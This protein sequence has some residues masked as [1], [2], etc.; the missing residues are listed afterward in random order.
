MENMRIENLSDVKSYIED[1]LLRL[2]ALEKELAALKAEAHP[3][4]DF[5]SNTEAID[6]SFDVIDNLV[7]DNIKEEDSISPIEVAEENIVN[8]EIAIEKEV[9]IEESPAVVEIADKEAESETEETTADVA[10]VT[11]ETEEAAIEEEEEEDYSESLFGSDFAPSA[12]PKGRKSKK[13][14]ILNDV[15][16]ESSDSVIDRLSDKKTWMRDIPGSEVKS[17][18]S[19]IALGDQVVYIRKLFRDDSA[20]YQDSIDK[21]N[22]MSSLKDAVQYLEST[23]PEWNMDS[24][25]VYRFM[26]AVRRRIRK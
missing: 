26:M 14:V 24:D 3:S 23:F 10:E 4:V 12:K 11:V 16:S 13:A 17:L 25:D 19:A 5:S 20:L 6:I 21:L 9:T 8:N 1:I 22:N 15:A 7:D 18:K 2:N